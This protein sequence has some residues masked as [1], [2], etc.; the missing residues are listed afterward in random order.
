MHRLSRLFLTCLAL[1]ACGDDDP[2]AKPGPDSGSPDAA[3][4]LDAKINLDGMVVRDAQPDA[5]DN[6][7]SSLPLCIVDQKYELRLVGGLP[8]HRESWELDAWRLRKTREADG[9][10][11]SCVSLIP[12][13]VELYGRLTNSVVTASFTEGETVYGQDSRP[14]DGSI[15]VIEREDGDQLWIADDCG[16][17]LNCRPIPLEVAALRNVILTALSAHYEVDPAQA[18]AAGN[19]PLRTVT[20]PGPIP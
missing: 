14:W 10:A 19:C 20:Q 7:D 9:G 5:H 17:A 4:Q 15:L 2:A 1:G 18:D 6:A 16:D 12:D 8:T 13:C 3:V 11:N